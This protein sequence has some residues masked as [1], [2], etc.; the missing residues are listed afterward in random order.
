ML[1]ILL[2]LIISYLV[3]RI[4]LR[5]LLTESPSQKRNRVNN[6]H[7]Y[8]SNNGDHRFNKKNRSSSSRFENVEDAEFEE[9][10][11]EEPGQKKE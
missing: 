8:G 2:I 9:I 5:L 7:P 6:T 10:P 3:I 4:T 11:K 1:R